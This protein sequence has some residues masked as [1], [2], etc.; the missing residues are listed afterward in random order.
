MLQSTLFQ[1]FPA[2]HHGFTTKK[3]INGIPIDDLF[4]LQ[5]IHSTDV[6]ELIS[7][8]MSFKADAVVTKKK[9]LAIGIKTSD[10][11]PILLFDP[12]QKMIA[13]AHAGWK[14]SLGNIVKNTVEKMV[15]LGSKVT[16]IHAVIGPAISSCCYDVSID[17]AMMF[18][19]QFY[20]S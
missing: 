4:T 10:C 20:F 9:Q 3:D 8:D 13:A 18:K 15:A 1:K 11:V 2:I 6:I 14:G 17:R 16:D 5:Q 12:K 19:D 7:N